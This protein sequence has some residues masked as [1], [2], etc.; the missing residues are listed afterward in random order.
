LEHLLSAWSTALAKIQNAN[1]VLFLSDF[2][3]TLAPIAEKPEPAVISEE[4]R[5]FLRDL[6]SQR[7][8]SPDWPTSQIHPYQ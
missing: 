4:T 1:H 6:A 2:D 7:H 5:N 8:T 3:G